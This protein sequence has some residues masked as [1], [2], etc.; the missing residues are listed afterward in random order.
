[1]TVADWTSVAVAGTSG[2]VAIAT[3]V[4]AGFTRSTAKAAVRAVQAAEVEA[5]ATQQLA[6]EAQRDRELV[7]QPVLDIKSPGTASGSRSVEIKNIGGGPALN[8]RCY[9]RDEDGWGQSDRSLSLPAR[10][11]ERIL[12]PRSSM[13]SSPDDLFDSPAGVASCSKSLVVVAVGEDV[14]GNR[15]RFLP[16]FQPEGPVRR[17][18]PA[19]PAWARILAAPS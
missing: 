5:A 16:G 8:V 4:L 15:W 11:A 10:S 6:S 19:P 17:D 13:G 14:L 3:L 12:V 1:M 7:Y 9:F 18:D 2:L